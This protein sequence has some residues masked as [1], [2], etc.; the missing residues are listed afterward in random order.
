MLPLA[1]GAARPFSRMADA[2]DARATLRRSL[3]RDD[4]LRFRTPNF[5]RRRFHGHDA[6]AE[7]EI[8]CAR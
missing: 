1:H 2:G 7:R 3:A 4:E 8:I 6:P 5:Y